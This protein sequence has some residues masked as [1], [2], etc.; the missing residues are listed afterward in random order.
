MIDWLM[1]I[2]QPLRNWEFIAAVVVIY[3]VGFLS[4]STLFYPIG[5]RHGVNVMAELWLKAG[6]DEKEPTE[7][8]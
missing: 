7:C 3:G 8:L 5:R 1:Q 4:G 2:T 6:R